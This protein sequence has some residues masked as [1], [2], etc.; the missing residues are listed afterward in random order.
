MWRRGPAPPARKSK[1]ARSA[2]ARSAPS[3]R[4]RLQVKRSPPHPRILGD[5]EATPAPATTLRIRKGAVAPL[6]AW[7]GARPDA[8]VIDVFLPDAGGLGVARALRREL[9]DVPVLFV[10]GLSLPSVRERLAP[11][12]V[13]MKPFTGQ[14]LLRSLQA[15]APTGRSSSAVAAGFG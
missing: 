2:A 12:P 7:Q 11:S 1:A 5:G 14:Q 15:L 13:L 4:A 8:A 10:T 3:S 6:P 9:A